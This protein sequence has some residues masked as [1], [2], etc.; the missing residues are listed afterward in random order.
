MKFAQTKWHKLRALS[1]VID[2][3]LWVTL[4]PGDVC[5]ASLHIFLALFSRQFFLLYSTVLYLCTASLKSPER[6]ILNL[7]LESLFFIPRSVFSK[8]EYVGNLTQHPSL[9][10]MKMGTKEGPK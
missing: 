2:T 1:R 5:L 9:L 10:T 4:A 6:T 7:F 3:L 8:S